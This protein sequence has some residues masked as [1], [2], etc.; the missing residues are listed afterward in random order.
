[1]MGY[2]VFYPMGF[3]DNGLPTE[4][5]VERTLGIEARSLNRAEFIKKCLETSESFGAEYRALWERIGLSIDWRY[6]YRTIDDRSRKI[7]QVSFLDLC[8]K[9]LVYQEMA[10]TI[11]C[12][13][14]QTAVAQAD[15]KDLQRDKDFHTLAFQLEDGSTLPIATTRPELLPACV[16]VF[17]HPDDDVHKH[18]VGKKAKVPFFDHEVP[19]YLDDTVD[20]SKGTGVV[21]CCTFGDA[22]D[23]DWWRRHNLPLNVIIDQS[24]KLLP[25]AGELAHLTVDLAYKKVIQLLEQ[26]N[27]VLGRQ[28][29][30]QSVRAHERCDTPVEFLITK[31]WFIRI[32]DYKDKLLEA[33]S[34]IDWYP[35]RMKRRYEQWVENLNMD[36]LISRQRYYGVPFP[37]WYCEDCGK[38]VFAELEQLPVDP[39]QDE[40][41]G[42]CECC[43]DSFIP[44]KDVMDTWAT[45][46]L[47]PQIACG[48]LEDQDRYEKSYPM[49][50]RSQAHEIIRTWAFY[51]IVK[52]LHHFE[53]IPWNEVAISGWGLAPAGGG[54]I[55]KSRGGGPVAPQEMIDRYSADA[56]RYWSA[57]TGLG[58]DAIINEEKIQAGSKLVT[59]L[60]NVARFSETFLRD[61]QPPSQIGTLLPIDT[62]ILSRTQ[63]V[64]DKAT[65]SFQA[66]DYVGAKNEV[67]DLFW[68]DLADN[69]LELVKF[70]LYGDQETGKRS[71][72]HALYHALRTILMLFAPFLPHVT[73]VIF[74]DLFSTGEGKRSIHVE[75]WPKGQW[76]KLEGES[77]AFGQMVLQ[78]LTSV[79]RYKSEKKLPLST[80]LKE[81]QLKVERSAMIRLIDESKIDLL[82][83]TRAEKV[84]VVEEFSSH[85]NVLLKDPFLQIAIVE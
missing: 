73:D 80:T 34:K 72:Q 13:E 78:V 35:D 18:L 39:M 85:S 14:C 2:D 32:M 36:W 61:Y 16:A 52:S 17:I 76:I 1:M 22:A 82:S 81:L 62:W 50:L 9:D 21:M 44:E 58:K 45:S 79:R 59:K 15:L 30:E 47:T 69:Y 83:A 43:G 71:A 8:Q 68:H 20:Q 4:R 60:W 6:T 53:Q 77:E 28:R 75:R 57:S 7:S 49:A 23:I 56:V 31:Q 70:R 11:W 29:T 25:T 55:S 63:S 42:E 27:L 51:T 12:P 74:Q 26:D 46:S 66:Y 41:F 64:L 19:I 24:G 40:P 67:E 3:D 38:P 5:L 48:W 10:P 84:E 33:S 65:K 54:K 37:V